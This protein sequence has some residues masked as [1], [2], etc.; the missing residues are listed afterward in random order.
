MP[1]VIIRAF[2]RS[3]IEKAILA[4]KICEDICDIFNV[5]G[6]QVRIYFEDRIKSNYFKNGKRVQ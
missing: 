4:K 5:T 3:D 6:D 2:K 1:E